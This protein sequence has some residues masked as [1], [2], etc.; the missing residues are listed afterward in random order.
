MSSIFIS[1]RR[2]ETKDVAGRLYDRL[3]A[4]FGRDRVF[5]D[6]Y[7]IPGGADFPSWIEEALT[8]SDVVV[9]LIG[10]RWATIEDSHNRRRIDDPAD[11]VRLEIATALEHDTLVIP[12]LVEGARMPAEAEL[13]DPLRTLPRHHAVELSDRRFEADMEGLIKV[14]RERMPDI[15]SQRTQPGDFRKLGAFHVHI[16]G[17]DQAHI[18]SLLGELGPT[19]TSK[20]NRVTGEPVR[21]PQRDDPDFDETYRYHTPGSLGNE[22]FSVFST[23]MLGVDSKLSPE[24][25]DALKHII[26]VVTRKAGPVVELERVVAT[27]DKDGVWAEVDLISDPTN[28]WKLSDECDYP[29]LSTFPI[30]I[31]HAIDIPKEGS[32]P[33]LNLAEDIPKGSNIGGWFLFEKETTWS[34][35]SNQFAD[36]SDY[37]HYAK[38][39]D[40][41]LR[42]FL[43]ELR[44]RGV[45][46]TLRTLV[47]QV[48]GIWRRDDELRRTDF[49]SVPDL[50]RWEMTCP[51]FWVVAA[52][53]LGDKSPDVKNAMV[54]NLKRRV[55]Y[56]YFVRSYADVF[57]LNM[58][59]KELEDELCE[60]MP[61]GLRREA[62][63][64][65]VSK[66]IR[67]V[68]LSGIDPSLKQLLKPD[69]FIC[70]REVDDKAVEG[71]KLQRGAI[72]G[73]K[74]DEDQVN[75]IIGGLSPLLQQKVEGFYLS[76][77]QEPWRHYD[78]PER[79]AIVCTDLD[80][81]EVTGGNRAWQQVLAIYDRIVAR[82]VSMFQ[83]GDIVRPVRNGYLLVFKSVNDAVEFT[84]RL[85]SAV[86]WH[87]DSSRR[88]RRDEKLP[89]HL[90]SLEYGLAT[91]VLR[92]HGDDYIGSAVD[93]SISRLDSCNRRELNSG[94]GAIAMSDTFSSSYEEELGEDPFPART[95]TPH[96]GWTMLL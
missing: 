8:S 57:R 7:T 25:I 30:E 3:T 52:N 91:R 83:Y 15:G 16:D 72:G 31:H 39:G 42:K 33:P 54:Q 81:S 44:E 93:K 17:D 21:G 13:P 65:V 35:R 62:A 50:A 76:V 92:A 24:A 96:D 45:E 82:E 6:V 47:E 94:E 37:E 80:S 85:Q 75:I 68:L 87:N 59:R 19:F 40:A 18:E 1:Y 86:A 77:P 48:L 10:D 67:C 9:V 38:D 43:A 4:I 58:L 74:I 88:A 41:R 27:I 90:V 51:E 79:Y 70:P 56:T 78:Y 95:R 14:L 20:V 69:Y 22:E 89:S 64:E 66:Q 53:F 23:T 55:T 71:Y 84:K 49:K 61:G 36:W 73:Q 46:A 28:L 32:L 63:R 2:D 34:Y 11:W 26:T 5:R 12:V 29:R 60:R